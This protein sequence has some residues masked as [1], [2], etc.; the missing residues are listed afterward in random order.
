MDLL[1]CMKNAEHLSLEPIQAFLEGTEELAF[2]APNRNMEC[3][4]G[5]K[6]QCAHS[7]T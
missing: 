5:R 1:I 7:A 2:E 3:M 6:R 4:P